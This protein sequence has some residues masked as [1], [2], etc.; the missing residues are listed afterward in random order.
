[1]VLKILESSTKGNVINLTQKIPI[2]FVAK[3]YIIE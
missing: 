3:H 1:M 2:F